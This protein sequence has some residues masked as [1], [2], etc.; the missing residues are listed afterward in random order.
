MAAHGIGS[1]ADYYL[2]DV[3][4]RFMNM[5][6]LKAHLAG[7]K[8]R[9]ELLRRAEI[10]ARHA[11]AQELSD[12]DHHKREREYLVSEAQSVSAEIFMQ[13]HGAR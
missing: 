2:G 9:A 10:Q 13:E 3:M 4:T 12:A 5:L 7:L 11:S 1:R 8:R 6:F